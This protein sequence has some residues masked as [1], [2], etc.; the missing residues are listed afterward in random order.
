MKI[1]AFLMKIYNF[2]MTNIVILGI[3]PGFSLIVTKATTIHK[4]GAAFVLAFATVREN[5]G[6]ILKQT[7]CLHDK[8]NSCHAKMLYCSLKIVYCS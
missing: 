8:M 1:I 3:D 7:I 5:P 2:V 4:M 6:S